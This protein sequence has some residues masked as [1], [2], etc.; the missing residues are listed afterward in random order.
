MQVL[1]L[2]AIIIMSR[3]EIKIQA[4]KDFVK[5]KRKELTMHDNEK[6]TDK[7]KDGFEKAKDFAHDAKENMAEKLHEGMDKL[8]DMK[9]EA[10]DKVKGTGENLNEQICQMLDNTDDKPYVKE[11][12]CKREFDNDIQADEMIISE[13]FEE[14]TKIMPEDEENAA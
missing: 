6:I 11:E 5:S 10:V 2:L 12:F 14:H 4:P 9:D 1:V 8:S 7:I 13:T 3:L